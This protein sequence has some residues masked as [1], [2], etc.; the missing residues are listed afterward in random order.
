MVGSLGCYRLE[1]PRG[2]WGAVWDAWGPA[3]CP[4]R[5][6][7]RAPSPPPHGPGRGAA[8]RAGA[9]HAP[10]PADGLWC[11]SPLGSA[12][13][14]PPPAG[15]RGCWGCRH[16][17][18]PSG[19]GHWQRP[20][21]CEQPTPG[22]QCPLSAHGRSGWPRCARGPSVLEDPA[23]GRRCGASIRCRCGA[24]DGHGRAAQ[25]SL[26]GVGARSGA[27]PM[28]HASSLLWSYLLTVA[29]PA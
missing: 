24:C 1:R 22:G 7:S 5:P 8:S 26:F 29:S 15:G 2:G 19:V 20:A 21:G 25:A 16:S 3:L 6:P 23:Q 17:G 9:S 27:A 10:R 18:G 28:V 4:P 11:G 13:T 12:L 14:P